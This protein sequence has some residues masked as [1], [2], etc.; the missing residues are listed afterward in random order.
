MYMSCID[1]TDGLDCGHSAFRVTVS[2]AL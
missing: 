1:L 2:L